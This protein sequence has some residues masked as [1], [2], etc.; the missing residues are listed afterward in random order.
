MTELLLNRYDQGTLIED[1]KKKQLA[2][3]QK[4]LQRIYQNSIFYR[5]KLDEAN[6]KPSDIKS[7]EDL[8]KIP[9]TSR[10][11]LEQ[12]FNSILA[13]PNSKVATIRMS[14]GTTGSP[15]KIAHT[16]KDVD[17]IADASA[18]RLTYHGA[19]NNDVVQ[20]TSAYGLWQGAW[21]MHWGAEK[22]GACIMPVG[23]ADTERQILLIKQFGT[24]ILYA[25]TN[26][27]FRILE[28]A[29]ALGEDLSK[30]RLNMAVCVAEKPTTTQIDI[31]KQQCGYKKVISDY[32]STECPGFSVNCSQ[33]PELHH[34][35]DDY[36]LVEVVDPETHEPLEEGQKGELVVTSL[37]REAFPLLRYL[38]R[39]ITTYY[40]Y[41]GCECGLVHPTNGADI[42]RE[43]PMTKIRGETVFPTH[44][45]FLLTKFPALTGRAQITVD[46]RTPR[47]EAILRAETAAALPAE[48]QMALKEEITTEIKARV[49]I[50]FSDVAFIPEGELESKYKKVIVISAP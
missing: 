15:L 12:N 14:S 50:A 4:Q 41:R 20:I 13:V 23:P 24:T 39:D 7:L 33:D 10:E 17:M 3:L 2:L 37:Q 1:L 5:N 32:G 30:Y 21:S 8:T 28:V 43:D 26:Y 19:T 22:I 49:G 11:E 18:R 46:K 42:D 40:G 27:H 47:H 16:K 25:A 34:V 31:L 29:K 6:V 9:L 36:Y 38:S 45:E 44:I 35:W 48:S